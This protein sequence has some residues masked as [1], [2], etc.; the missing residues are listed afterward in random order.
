MGP[1]YLTVVALSPSARILPS[2]GCCAHYLT[3]S[4]INQSYSNLSS[5][6]NVHQELLFPIDSVFVPFFWIFNFFIAEYFRKPSATTRLRRRRR[7][8]SICITTIIT[9]TTITTYRRTSLLSTGTNPNK[10]FTPPPPFFTRK[11]YVELL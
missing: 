5:R 2:S 8:R 1:K 7:L 11:K 3:N 4:L 6:L 9:I 10:C